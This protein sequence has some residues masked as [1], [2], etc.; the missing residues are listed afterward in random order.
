[1]RIT[2]ADIEIARDGDG[3]VDCIHYAFPVSQAQ[4]E[5]RIFKGAPHALV[6][7]RKNVVN[8]LVIKVERTFK[9]YE[10]AQ[11]FALMQLAD[12]N[13]QNRGDM[14]IFSKDRVIEMKNAVVDVSAPEEPI[15]VYLPLTYTF[16]GGQILPENYGHYEGQ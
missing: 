4:R 9:S 7:N 11:D 8:T 2:F 13:A 10:E 1:M 14:K 3:V 5:V 16:T 12:I 6:C 15:G